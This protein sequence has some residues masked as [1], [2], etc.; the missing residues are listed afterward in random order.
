MVYKQKG[1]PMH[2]VSAL[3]QK[4]EKETWKEGLREHSK[5]LDQEIKALETGDKLT[6]NIIASGRHKKRVEDAKKQ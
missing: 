5:N 3:K 4:T 6:A 2:S 1:F